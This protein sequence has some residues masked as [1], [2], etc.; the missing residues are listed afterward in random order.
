MTDQDYTR[1]NNSATGGRESQP[2][3]SPGSNA[4]AEVSLAA[5]DSGTKAREFVSDTVTTVSDH[6]KDMLDK[7]LGRSIGA[8]GVF[9][10]AVNRAAR[11][12]NAQS[13]VAASI[14]RSA[15]DRVEQFAED[16]NDETVE[17]LVRSASDF[18]RRQPALVFGL[19]ALAGFFVFRAITSAT[20][21]PA[22]PSIQPKDSGSAA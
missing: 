13:P 2:D 12:L 11:E 5:Q 4:F 7:E 19:T 6:F 18:T 17:Q 16:Y 22:S 21:T 9:A 1:Q 10:G 20:S 14:V 15:A 8:A 3:E